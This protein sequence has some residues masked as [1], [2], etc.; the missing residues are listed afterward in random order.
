MRAWSSTAIQTRSGIL[1]ASSRSR[2][3]NCR[4]TGVGELHQAIMNGELAR[5]GSLSARICAA[6]WN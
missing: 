5:S 4:F 1:A 2:R 3:M 6:K